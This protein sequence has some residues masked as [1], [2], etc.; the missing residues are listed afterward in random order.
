MSDDDDCEKCGGSGR[1]TRGHCH[2]SRTGG[3]FDLTREDD[4]KNCGGTGEVTC[5]KFNGSG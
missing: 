1:E 4:C 5:T 2:G 3:S